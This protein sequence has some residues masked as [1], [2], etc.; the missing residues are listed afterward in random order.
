V[1]F[2]LLFVNRLYSASNFITFTYRKYVV[3]EINNFNI[4]IAISVYKMNFEVKNNLTDQ[5]MPITDL[6][7]NAVN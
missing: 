7:N 6:G 3:F 5:I 4:G 1:I 2:I